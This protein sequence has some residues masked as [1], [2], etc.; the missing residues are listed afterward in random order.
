M[1]K[2]TST[3]LF[4]T[5]ISVSNAQT[6]TLQP[7][8]SAG[9]DAFI[10]SLQP[11]TN[12]G[13]AQ[14]LAAIAWTNS[15]NATTVRGLLQFDLSS[16]PPG[17]VINSATLFLYHNPL[18]VNTSAQHQSLSGSNEGVI[19]KIITDWDEN[20][21]TWNTQPSVTSINEV[22][23]PES[24]TATQNYELNVTA[25]VQDMVDFPAASYGFQ[26]RLLS[27]QYYRS[28]IF[29]SSDNTDA[30]NHPKLVI[31]YTDV[32]GIDEV[33]STTK[34]LV[35]IT[36]LIG[37]EVPFSKNTPLL[38]IFEDGSVQRTLEIAE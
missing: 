11:T 26:I 15:G 30:T 2:L 28:L 16:I 10:N 24:A 31:N 5:A 20:T 21:V 34:K 14:D 7:N 13:A 18:S 38:L 22:T 8:A 4:L 27:E 23:I 19:R 35:R 17:S 12:G 37:R 25:M 3:I 6:L 29:A 33:Q 1:K 32:A 9:K 36:D